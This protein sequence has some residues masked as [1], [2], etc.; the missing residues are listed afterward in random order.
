MWVRLPPKSL[1][2][3][4][5]CGGTG[6]RS[7]LKIHSPNKAWGFDSP[8]SHLRSYII[9]FMEKIDWEKEDRKTLI[10]LV[11]FSLN[12][13]SYVKEMDPELWKKAGEYAADFTKEE[14]VEFTPSEE[15]ENQS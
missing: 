4:R 9:T 13:A 7:G 2:G 10:A 3:N 1:K 5:L 8:R 6:R 11:K 14:G 15:D 12:F